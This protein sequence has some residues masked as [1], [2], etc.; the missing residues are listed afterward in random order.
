MSVTYLSINLSVTGMCFN[1]LIAGL[2]LN[3]VS[4]FMRFCPKSYKNPAIFLSQTSCLLFF[5]TRSAKYAAAKTTAPYNQVKECNGYRG[6][7]RKVNNMYQ[8]LIIRSKNVTKSSLN[9]KLKYYRVS[10]PY[11]QV[12][13]CNERST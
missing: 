4:L 3:S 1:P 12:K 11:N 13:E 10:I 8:S 2:F 6:H 9:L 5:A 7:V